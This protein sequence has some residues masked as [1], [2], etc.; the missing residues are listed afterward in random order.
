MMKRPTHRTPDGA[1]GVFHKPDADKQ[2]IMRFFNASTYDIFAAGYLFD[3]VAGKE[4]R[5]PLAAVQRDG[6]AWSNRDAYY[7]EKYDM[8]LDP[9]F[10]EYALAHAPEA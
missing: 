8:Q 9:E 2:R 7:F 5:I 3:E 4:T 6:F 10:R 1:Y